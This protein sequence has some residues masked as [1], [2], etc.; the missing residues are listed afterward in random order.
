MKQLFFEL[1]QVATGQRECLERGPEPEEWQA[2]HELAQRQAVAGI[3]Y[4]G[5]ERLF[6]FG[7]RAP[8]DVSIDWMAEAEEIKEQNEQTKTPS[9][10]MR[11]YGEDMR[12]LRQ[13]SDEYYVQNK[14]MTIE[15]VYRL[16]LEQRLNMRVVMDYNY[17]LLKTEHRYETLKTSGFLHVFLR[18]F[19]IRRFARGMMWVLKETMG[20]ERSQMLCKP[21][22]H[23]GRFI[24]QEMIDG[25]QKMEMLKRYQRL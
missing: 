19:G 12:N 10:A 11:Y 1:I 16:F 6:E 3:C 5:V 8:Q 17:L 13:P 18:Y 9:Y 25:H 15:D 20:M 4:R 14:P 2:L 7:L 22:R 21:S 24:L 23:E